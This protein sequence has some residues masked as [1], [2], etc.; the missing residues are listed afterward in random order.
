M[1]KA[2]YERLTTHAPLTALVPVSNFYESGAADD[3]P[4]RPYLVPI[5]LPE[6]R[7]G[8]KYVYPCEIR[9]HDERGSYA[10]IRQINQVVRDLLVSVEQYHGTDGWLVQ[11]DYAGC[12]GD[13]V[14]PESGTN[15]Q[16][17]SWEIVGR[18]E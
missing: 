1:I 6:L 16:Y 10:R 14:D 3:R 4:V 17:T 18:K 9:V 5:W 15:F 7:K 11:C 2:L 8:R 12:S 13:L